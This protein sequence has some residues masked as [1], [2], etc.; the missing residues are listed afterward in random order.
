MDRGTI[1]QL[2]NL[3]IET[4]YMAETDEIFAKDA[5]ALGEVISCLRSI[6]EAEERA[7]RTRWHTLQRGDVYYCYGSPWAIGCEEKKLRPVV[8]LQSGKSHSKGGMVTVAPVSTWK[9]GQK[10]YPSQ[11][12]IWLPGGKKSRVLCEQ[13]IS[14]DKSRFRGRRVA[15]LDRRKMQE[16]D[17]CLKFHL[18]IA[19]K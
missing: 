15:T 4:Q 13:M 19:E 17:R 14:V 9:P 7:K 18:G 3:R 5:D 12:I 16:M 11:F 1:E 6:V 10:L 2:E 8:V